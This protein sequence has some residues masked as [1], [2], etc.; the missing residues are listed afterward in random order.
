MKMRSMNIESTFGA[1]PVEFVDNPSDY[2]FSKHDAQSDY[3]ILADSLVWNLYAE[4]FPA[5]KSFPR[6]IVEA[7]EETKTLEKVNQFSLWMTKN[8]CTKSTTILA[9]GG[10][11]IQDLATFT[12]R[13]FHRGCSWE[14]HPTTLLGQADS[15]IGSKC[16][17]NVMPFKNQLGTIYAPK[18]VVIHQY[19]L[20]S[21]PYE[22]ILSGFGEILKL[23]ITGP[24]HFYD[25]LRSTLAHNHS[26]VPVGKDL[27]KLVRQSLI[28][29][30]F[31]IEEDELEVGPR[32]ILNYGHS[33]GHALESLSS[34]TI[35]HGKAIVF[36][37]D[38]I[39]YLGVS[40]GI[41]DECFYAEFK[42]LL[43]EIYGKV[44]MPKDV[45]AASL[46]E[47][48]RS[49]KKMAYGEITFAI[50]VREG[51]IKLVKKHLDRDLECL[52]TAYLRDENVFTIA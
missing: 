51:H 13:I 12:A 22:E 1:Y 7:N 18:R 35:T 21:L 44:V 15:C 39:N 37:M 34:N 27:H 20:D 52:V 50:P 28:A 6:F 45:T 19:L 4:N 48:L 32:R 8:G 43:N 40:W 42:T 47:Q 11:V 5:W 23:S 31:V 46:V 26:R 3:V 49:D 41:T 36:G 17:I 29:K 9:F 2:S 30:K 24:G 33:F 25:E 38:L 10:G 16:G 14:Y